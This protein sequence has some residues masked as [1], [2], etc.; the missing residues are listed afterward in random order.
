MPCPQAPGIRPHIPSVQ[1]GTDYA[2]A[3]YLA[4]AETCRCASDATAGR[5]APGKEPT[6]RQST[7]MEEQ[8]LAKP[9]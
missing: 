6:S 4:H 5:I 9:S 1:E 8:G 3:K 2:A 7:K